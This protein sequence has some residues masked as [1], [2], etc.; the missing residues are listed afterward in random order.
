MEFKEVDAREGV[1][2]VLVSSG[3]PGADCV[4]VRLCICGDSWL[5]R[6]A[7]STPPA[8]RAGLFTKDTAVSDVWVGWEVLVSFEVCW[9]TWRIAM[10]VESEGAKVLGS[11]FVSADSI[12]CGVWSEEARGFCSIDCIVKG[13]GSSPVVSIIKPGPPSE[14]LPS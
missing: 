3:I 13:I 10:G 4:C 14:L 8:A 1:V 7:K 11:D 12:S 5:R 9:L 2:D 6:A